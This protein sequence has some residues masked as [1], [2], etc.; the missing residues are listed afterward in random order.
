MGKKSSPKQTSTSS[1]SQS[2]WLYDNKDMQSLLNNVIS[3]SQGMPDYQ[4]AGLND[5][6]R[7]AL[8][9]LIS[10]R[11]QSTLQGQSEYLNDQSIK[12]SSAGLNQ[13]NDAAATFNRYSNMSNAD[14]NQM[15][16]DATNSGLVNTQKEI[17]TRNIQK[18]LDKN[19][20]QLN[21]AASGTG[22]M[23]SSR[24]GVAQGVMT[25]EAMTAIGD[26]NAAIDQ[27]AYQNAINSVN[28]Q[29]GSSLS[30]A[31]QLSSQ[32]LNFSQMG[33]SGLNSSM[34]WNNQ[35]LNNKIADLNNM[36]SAGSIYQQDSQNNMNTNWY[37]Q[38]NKDNPYLGQFQLLYNTLGGT[39]G[40]STSGTGTSTSKTSGGSS[41]F[42]GALG[43]LAGA[44]IGGWL[45]G[46]TG[47]GIGSSVGGS[48]GSIFG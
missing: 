19:V 9:A 5:T 3:N 41:G 17:S 14:Y 40:W 33:M 26:A 24:A 48:F 27:N 35:I 32:G 45:G 37:N 29:I 6:Q 4:Y 20:N 25:G 44:G 30:A 38:I 28:N 36:F 12:F 10:G 21:Q 18:A 47:A 34:G 46:S 13:A 39:A 11:D 15:I 16:A 1:S 42:G 43:G 22:N 23:G 31:G 8:E 7:N 2:S